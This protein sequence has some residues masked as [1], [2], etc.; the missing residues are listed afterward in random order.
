MKQMLPSISDCEHFLRG[1]GPTNNLEKALLAK[2]SA[3]ELRE[4]ARQEKK[5]L[6]GYLAEKE[7]QSKTAKKE[8]E[9]SFDTHEKKHQELTRRMRAARE[10]A[11]PAPA[12][13]PAIRPAARATPAPAAPARP[14]RDER[15]ETLV[16]ALRLPNI[17][18]AEREAIHAEL[19]HR[20]VTILKTGFS[21]PII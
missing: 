9:S 14:H 20:G 4:M 16:R 8:R 3:Q 15:S 17:T 7:R 21:Q 13:R 10:A 18:E 11:R 6:D 12:P 2:M 1:D 5:S 19:Q